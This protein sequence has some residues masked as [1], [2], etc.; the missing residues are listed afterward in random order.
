MDR[1]YPVSLGV[2]GEVAFGRSN[3]ALRFWGLG[4]KAAIAYN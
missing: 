4:A 1:D 3:K 2:F